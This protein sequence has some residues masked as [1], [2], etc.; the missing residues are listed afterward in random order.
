MHFDFQTEQFN[1]ND[2]GSN[3]PFYLYRLKLSS[4]IYFND[5][6]KYLQNS[7]RR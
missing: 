2:R 5:K 1:K 3:A 7:A 6:I 4:F